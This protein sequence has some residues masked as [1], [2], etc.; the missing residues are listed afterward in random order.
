MELAEV[1]GLT[2]KG[3]EWSL[4]KLKAQGILKRIGRARGG[5]WEVVKD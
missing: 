1:S 4:R 2:T 5:R 3:I